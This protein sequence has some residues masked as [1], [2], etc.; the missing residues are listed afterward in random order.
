MSTTHPTTDSATDASGASAV[1]MRFEI[2][3]LPVADPDR[4]KAF[5]ASLGWR[6][7]AEAGGGPYRVIQMTPP[8]SNA[9]IIFGKGITDAEPGSI[10]RLLLTVPDVDA[11]RDELLAQGADVSEVFHD[12][13]G[14]P[15]GGFHPGTEGR[16]PGRDPDG[17]SYASYASFRD[18]DGNHWLLQEVTERLPGRIQ[19]IDVP[20]RA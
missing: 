8:G 12:A 17:R 4:T 14:T 3:I 7:D 13:R 18:P 9:S 10:D 11:A 19:P 15:G 2:A 5:Y 20:A 1:P 6:V 16:A